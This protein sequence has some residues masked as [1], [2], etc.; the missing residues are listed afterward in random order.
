[1]GEDPAQRPMDPIFELLLR[2]ADNPSLDV[3]IPISLVVGGSV[4]VGT[5][6]GEY[7]FYRSVVPAIFKG[8]KGYPA[9]DAESNSREIISSADALVKARLSARMIPEF[10]HV[11]DAVVT[12][13]DGRQTE[14]GYW[15]ARVDRV[16]GYCLVGGAPLAA[17]SA[18]TAHQ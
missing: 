5:L 7:L 12:S 3:A 13:P 6:V 15:R 11:R 9:E 14:N 10:V 1:M 8:L 17:S 4:V 2:M 18:E 16:D